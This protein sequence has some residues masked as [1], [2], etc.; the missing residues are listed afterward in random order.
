[1]GDA[2]K[3]ARLRHDFRGVEGNGAALENRNPTFVKVAQE[4][5]SPANIDAAKAYLDQ[6]AHLS[7]DSD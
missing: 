3:I 2:W 1:V 6:C 7:G 5:F 4:V